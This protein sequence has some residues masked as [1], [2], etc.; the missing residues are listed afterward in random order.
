MKF[1]SPILNRRTFLA[2]AGS[3][4]LASAATAEQTAG[5]TAAGTGGSSSVASAAIPHQKMP[6]WLKEEGLVMAGV[7]W[8]SLLPRLR[9]RN[10]DLPGQPPIGYNRKVAVWRAE[11]SEAVARRLKQMGF[12]FL[13]IPLYKGGSLEAERTSM[14]DAKQF[15]KICHSLGLR[16]GCYA[17]SGTI[18]YES[19]LA[20]TPAASEWFTQNHSGQDVPYGSLYFRRYA[21]RNHPGMRAFLRNI[22][23]FAVVEAQVDLIHF[24]NYVVGPSYEPYSVADF[25]KYLESRYS[26]EQRKQRFGFAPM[27]Y[28]IPPPAPRQTDEYNGDPLYQ[29]FVDYRCKVMADTYRELAE[30]ARSLNPEIM[31]ELNPGGY[32]GELVTSL[33]IGALDHTRTLQW[34]G[35]FWDEGSP[36]HLENGLLLSRFRSQM[37]GRYFEN[38]VFDYTAE[39]VAIAESM[40]NNLQCL[41][42]PAWVNG[43]EILP[44]LPYHGAHPTDQFDPM[45]TASIR[46]FHDHQQYFRDTEPV[47]DI[48]VLNT[49]INTAYGPAI[50]H[51]RWTAATQ[52]LYQ[53][54][55]P[56]TLVP[57]SAPGDLSRFRVLLLPDLNLVSDSLIDLLHSYVRQGGGLVMTGQ[58]TQF[59]EHGHIRSRAGLADLFPEPLGRQP[60]RSHGQR[61]RAAYLPQIQ[62][63]ENFR[64]G[65][66]P[67][68]QADLLDAIRWAAGGPLQIAV[69]APT[70]VTMSL[71]RQPT[72]RH[73]LHLVNY[74]VEH[75]ARNIGVTL[76][77][78]H[79]K[80]TSSIQLLSPEHAGAKTLAV[81]QQGQ[82]IHFVVPQL[83]T[84]EMLVIG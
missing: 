56:F 19:M 20:E 32:R 5:G 46:F 24:D 3:M 51:K 57:D 61:S 63:P 45:V 60:L 38:M 84:Y 48:G 39:P 65:M 53:A 36:S 34:G 77:L 12:N 49:Y 59:D 58:S 15:T 40:A 79:A 66:L 35:A 23:H 76:D 69:E 21:N 1:N 71:Y 27:D 30:Y 67:E 73:I 55:M 41:G 83:K 78:Q 72:G 62:I 11:H 16:V 6:A 9:F 10:F 29:D 8:E 68:N 17:F 13:M 25:R 44:Y 52:A 14:E 74:D 81:E 43:S 22:V 70:T 42:C 64:I 75:P 18:L 2:G 28:V 50:T 54:K 33:G 4:L 82:A 37:M 31:M 47:A 7:D 80:P 26:P